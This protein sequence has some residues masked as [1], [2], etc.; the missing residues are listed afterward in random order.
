MVVVDEPIAVDDVIAVHTGHGSR[1]STHVAGHSAPV[2]LGA[3]GPGAGG[4][5]HY[6]PR[7]IGEPGHTPNVPRG[8]GHLAS[9]HDTRR[10][11]SDV[12]VRP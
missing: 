12:R 10:G 7:P 8:R 1:S 5:G 4:T 2:T 6:A 3:H 11:E 9:V